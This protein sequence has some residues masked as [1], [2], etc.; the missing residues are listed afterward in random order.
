MTVLPQ[1]ERQLVRAAGGGRGGPRRAPGWTA[2]ALGCAI[3]VAVAVAFATVGIRGPHPRVAAHPAPVNRSTAPHQSIAVA[4]PVVPASWAEA[5]AQ[6]GD[7]EPVPSG[8]VPSA[9]RQPFR[10]PLLRP[11]EACPATPGS[12]FTTGYIGGP[13]MGTAPVRAEI[14][15]QVD[16]RDGRIVL[17]TTN[18]RGW[19]GIEIMWYSLPSYDGPWSVRAVRLSG[20]GRIDLG[21]GPNALPAR[22]P[23][24]GGSPLSPTALVVPPGPTINTSDG[25][26][27]DPRTTW[28]TAPGCYAW[29][30]NGLNFS[31]LIVFQALPPSQIS[32]LP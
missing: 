15:N 23:G 7:C 18:V 3:V 2:V 17:G 20:G 30:V 22:A 14:G 11:G 29:Q 4:D 1:L 32:G 24:R 31:Q 28:V 26:R 5:C 19:F 9:L 16:L 10:V 21:S 8:S 12:R 6:T 25:Y 13:E 27:T